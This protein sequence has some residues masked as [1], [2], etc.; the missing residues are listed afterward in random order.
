MTDNFDR[1][2]IPTGSHPSIR[3]HDLP[4]I[5]GPLFELEKKRSGLLA[6]VVYKTKEELSNSSLEVILGEA[7]YSERIRMKREAFNPFTLP[8]LKRDR[9]LWNHI[10]SG[11]LKSGAEVDRTELLDQVIRHYAEEIG[12]HFDPRVYP[13]AIRAVPWLFS[14]LLNAASVR[15]FLPWGM[16]EAL[17]SRLHIVGE[18]PALQELINKGTILLVPTHQ[19][20]IDS[21]L[22]GYV[23]YLMSLPPFAYGAGL[24]LFSNPLL[25][26]FMSRLGSYTVDRQKRN[27]IYKNTLK[28]YSRRILNE[29]IHSIFFPGGG[30]SRSGAIENHLKLGLLGTGLEAQIDLLR[31]GDPNKRVFIVPMV[32]SYHFVLEASSLIEDYLEESGKFRFIIRGDESRQLRKVLGFFWKFFS[33]PSAVTVR[34]GKPL[35][36]FGNFVDESGQSIGPNG[37]TIDPRKWLTTG[38]ELKSNPQRDSEYTRELGE[39]L[40]ERFHK[41]NT[42][43]TSHLVAFVVFETLRKKYPDFDLFRFLR[44]SLEQRSLP[45]SQFLAAAATYQAKILDY[46]NRGEL[47]ISDE[48]RTGDTEAWTKDGIKHL[49]YLHDAAVVKLNGDVIATE[50]MNLLYYYRNRLAGYGLSL[51]CEKMGSPTYLRQHDTQGFLA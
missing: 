44:L 16:T 31:A 24:N 15:R 1:P 2:I 11:L 21:V 37:T 14:W 42:V 30:R 17:G 9:K 10:Q 8:R 48:L 32:T 28:N 38:G 41:E 3:F 40:S 27:G 45:Y 34:I 43:L 12:G 22:L 35:D 7:L 49:G 25:G 26:F 6:D 46:A 47:Y 29:G 23:I 4:V 39:R 33:S 20:N 36:V 50:D 18:V 5:P 13:F 51:R 19:S